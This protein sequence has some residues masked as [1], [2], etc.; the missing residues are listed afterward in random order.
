M[1]VGWASPRAPIY[2]SSWA[3]RVSQGYQEIER[4]ARK[5]GFV[6]L[7]PRASEAPT[8][9]PGWGKRK[10]GGLAPVLGGAPSGEPGPSHAVAP[11]YSQIF[12]DGQYF[13]LRHRGVV[14]W[15]QQQTVQRRVKRSLVVPT[16]P[17][18]SKQWYMGIVV[19]V[20][21][22]GIEKDHPD[23]W[24]NYVSL[25]GTRCAGEVAAMANNRFC[26]AGVA[27]NAR[28]GGTQAR[29]GAGG[30]FT[31]AA[32][33]GVRMLDGTIT[34]VIE[35]QPA[36]GVLASRAAAPSPILRVMHVRKNVSACIG[37]ANYIRSLEHV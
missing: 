29:R 2:V 9:A 25:H 26:G 35:A 32:C 4:L 12:P 22:D 23:L 34:D 3:V 28:I 33:A 7:G 27:Y 16:D 5:F 13:H 21:D 18:F 37:H 15:F 19:S 30:V 6:N 14:Q 17:W 36:G 1:A 10:E 31:E 20:L 8:W 11:L 24:A